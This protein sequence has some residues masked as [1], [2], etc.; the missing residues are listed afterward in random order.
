[1]KT[2]K[3]SIL[4]SFVAASLTVLTVPLQS[5]DA[6]WYKGVV[7]AHANWG[8]PQL[9]TTSPDVVV[10][11]YREHNYNFVS[12]TDLNYYTPPEG[13][14]ALFDAPGRFLV[15]PGTEPSKDPIQPG[16]KIVDTI[17]IGISGPVAPPEGETVSA[18]LDSEAK[19][20]RRAGGLPI[21]AHPNLTYALT[22]ADLMTSD[23]T[24]GPRFFELWNTEPGM[25]NLGGG[26]KP[27]TEQIWDTVLSSGRV[28]YGTA[29]DD[30][31]HFY[32]F[33]ASRET[34]QPLSNPGK[35]WIMVRAPELSV[36]ALL[37]AMNKG[38]FYASTGVVLDSYEVSA[39]GI[40]IG[41]N[42]RTHDLGWSLPGANPQLYRTEFIG[43]DGKVL[44]LDESL[45][46]SFTFT[47]N[48]LYVRAR[49]ISSDGQLAWTQPVFPKR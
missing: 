13:L 31:H 7:H 42:D 29:V 5:A 43:K 15:V 35:A 39:T 11:W 16:N 24:A 34:G 2:A 25:N 37:E 30:S 27:S 21:A 41:L 19:A 6:P 4:F 38:D 22:A 1:V 8:A 33:V 3:I 47:G 45:A 10:R 36:K 23:K 49:I 18:V 26:G 44:K 20:I 28:M 40:R 12:V 17:G 48:E 32:D 46:P 14:K 9:P